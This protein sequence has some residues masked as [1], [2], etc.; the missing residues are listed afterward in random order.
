MRSYFVFILILSSGIFYSQNTETSFQM[1]TSKTDGEFLKYSEI[2]GTPYLNKEFAPGKA[3]CC[4]ETMPMRYDLYADQIEYSKEGK[5][6]ILL[7]QEPYSRILFKDSGTTL[8]LADADQN[9]TPVYLVLL[10]EGKEV[11]L[12][13]KLSAKI[14]TSQSNGNGLSGRRSE[15]SS[16]ALN[17]P[18]YYLKVNNAYHPIK[19]TKD[20]SD[21]FPGKEDAIKAYLKAN[22]VKFNKEESLIKFV[23]FL[24]GN[25]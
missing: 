6:Y 16:F 8:I 20:V 12:L 18:S 13:K 19:S 22:K 3:A 1:T 17:A 15:T 14:E 9:G 21:L 2:T 24:N 7:K 4:N 10:N 25:K 23:G 5:I 11:S